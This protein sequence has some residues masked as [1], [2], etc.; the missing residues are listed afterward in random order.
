MK[1]FADNEFMEAQP[2]YVAKRKYSGGVYVA[3]EVRGDSMDDESK[4]SICH[5]DVVLGRELYQ[6]Y[7]NTK[8]HIPK[9]FVIVH[10]YEGIC[11]KEIIRHDVAS[12]DITCHSFNQNYEDFNVNL[13]DVMKLFYIK[14]ISRDVE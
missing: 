7:W 10:K 11:I 12:G 13:A 8:L 2:Q 9:V 5:G 3:F 6:H 1:G 4:K 14:E